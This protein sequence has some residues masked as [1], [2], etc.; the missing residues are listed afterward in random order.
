M[1]PSVRDM[2]AARADVGY[3]A[4]QA[5][6]LPTVDPAR[7]LGVRMPQV[8]RLAR[9]LSRER[10]EMA[11]AFLAELP[12]ATYDEDMLHAVLLNDLPDLASCAAALDAFLPHVDNWAVCDAL[13]PRA[14]KAR[15]DGLL[16][17]V[18]RWMGSGRPFTVRFGIGVLMRIYLGEGFEPGQLRR[19]A[20]VRSG[21]YYVRMMV[22]WYV[23]TALDRQWDATLPCLEGRW[24]DPW[25]HRKA[26]QKVVESY[27]IPAE[28]KAY[29]RA[30]R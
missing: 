29:L 14:F 12:H 23:A 5:R 6:L 25:T 1:A 11:A 26:I 21:E 27:R 18:E 20:A 3:R 8:R 19:V 13:A 4:F 16:D 2:L 10:P 9:G 7:I 22:A 17:C 24:L 30:L 15:P 28:R